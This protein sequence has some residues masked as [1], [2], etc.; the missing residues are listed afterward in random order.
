MR[1]KRAYDNFLSKVG[2]PLDEGVLYGPMH[3]QQGVDGY[4]ATLE[5]VKKAGGEH[6]SLL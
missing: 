1:L 6:L 5:E 4:L 2:D 3:S